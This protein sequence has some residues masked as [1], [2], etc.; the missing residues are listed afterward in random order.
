MHAARRG[1]KPRLL[2][3]P[4]WQLVGVQDLEAKFPTLILKKKNETVHILLLWNKVLHVY[5]TKKYAGGYYIYYLA[6]SH[7]LAGRLTCW[8]IYVRT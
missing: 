2:Q 6:I 5:K 4:D 7:T 8:Y 1:G 3:S